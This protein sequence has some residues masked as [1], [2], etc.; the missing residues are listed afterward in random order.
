M[1]GVQ[2]CALPICNGKAEEMAA[3]KLDNLE[4]DITLLK[5]AAEGF[6]ISLYENMQGPLREWVQFGKDQIGI[7]QEALDSGGFEGLASAIGDV[8]ANGVTKFADAAPDFINGA[9]DVVEALIDGI[10]GKSPVK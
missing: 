9:A 2:T 5:S 1:T 10:D 8:L 6:G 3:I 4:G 7:L